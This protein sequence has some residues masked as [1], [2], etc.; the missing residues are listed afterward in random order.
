MATPSKQKRPP[1]T[2]GIRLDRVRQ[3]R[4][5]NRSVYLLQSLPGGWDPTSDDGSGKGIFELANFVW[6]M[7]EGGDRMPTPED[8][9]DEMPLGDAEAIAEIQR[10][11]Q[12]AI[13]HAKQGTEEKNALSGPSLTPGS[14][15]G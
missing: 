8:V 10:T 11:I 3:I 7:L 1:L 5:S 9:A 4:W 14:S 2:W 6:A 13:A 15:A 12:E